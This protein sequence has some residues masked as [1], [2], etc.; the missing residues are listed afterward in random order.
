MKLTLKEHNYIIDAILFDM[1]GVLVDSIP[2]HIDA[3]NQVIKDLGFPSIQSQFFSDL[4]GK[5]NRDMLIAYSQVHQVFLNEIQFEETL[6]TKEAVFRKKIGE[7]AKTTPGIFDWLNF[8]HQN[9][10]P[11]SV[12]SS[13]TME[14]ITYVLQSLN[15]ADYFTTIISGANLSASKPDPRIFLSAAASL[16]VA[17]ANCLVIEDAPVG[18][19]AAKSANMICCA[20]TTSYEKKYLEEADLIVE[21]LAQIPPHSLFT[22]E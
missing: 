22:I 12:A 1:D 21:S 6:D 16:N 10:I 5:T 9:D 3:W 4:L 8:L 11:C 2:V 7:E 14:N 15:I 18:I 20:I 13:S 19:Q 17:A